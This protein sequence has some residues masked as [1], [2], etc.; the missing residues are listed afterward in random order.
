MGNQVQPNYQGQQGNF[1]NQ[2]GVHDGYNNNP[3]IPQS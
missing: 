2:A 1:Y 3:N